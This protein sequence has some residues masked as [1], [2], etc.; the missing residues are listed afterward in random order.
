MGGSLVLTDLAVC[1]AERPET[2][3]KAVTRM[4]VDKNFCGVSISGFLL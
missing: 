3:T 4:L 2:E 1:A